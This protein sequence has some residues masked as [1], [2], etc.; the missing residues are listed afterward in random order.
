MNYTK[1]VLLLGG[2]LCVSDSF[3][4]FSRPAVT[5]MHRVR[6]VLARQ[7]VNESKRTVQRGV[8]LKNFSVRAMP[9]VDTQ[10]FG[11]QSDNH[12][13]GASVYCCRGCDWR[14][15]SK[16]PKNA[17][18]LNAMEQGDAAKARAVIQ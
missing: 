14:E 15:K 4:F 17:A 13:Q 16:K 6:S 1:T 5:G 11:A 7:V 2:L 3:S 12:V 8:P 10:S 9:F 18:L